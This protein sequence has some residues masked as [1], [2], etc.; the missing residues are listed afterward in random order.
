[1]AWPRGGC[2]MSQWMGVAW[3]R[4]RVWHGSVG[5]CGMAQWVGEAWPRG[6]CGMSQWMGVAWPSGWVW[7][8]PWVCE[9]LG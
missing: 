2:G 7:H 8:G 4:E 1:M 6:G 3:P 9:E 5:G